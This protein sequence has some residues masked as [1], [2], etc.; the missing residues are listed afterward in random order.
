MNYSSAA[1]LALLVHIIIHFNVIRNTHYRKEQP[2]AK[3]YRWMILSVGAFYVFDALWGV[4]YSARL[5]QAVAFDTMLYFLSMG[6]TMFFW[7]RF[8]VLYL[9]EKN[10]FAKAISIIGCLLI[11]MIAVLLIINLFTPV[12]FWFDE[13]GVYHAGN[14][15]YAILL[16]QIL[17]FILASVYLMATLPKTESK[18]RKHHIAI[19]ISGITVAAM[20]ILQAIF[21]LQPF[22]SI[23]CLLGTCIIHTF[24]VGDMEYDRRIELEE[25]L[26]REAQ[27][28]K[29]LGSAKQLAYTDSLTGVKSSHA[30][31]EI[32][33][34]VDQRI[35][36][37]DIRE[38]GVVVFDLNGLKEINDTKGHDAGNQYIQGGCRIICE[39]FKHS[40]VFRI[41]GDEFVAFLEGEDFRN[42]KIILAAFETQIDENVRSGGPVVASGMA[43]FRHGKDNSY[44][45]VFERADQR[46]YDRK[47]VLKAMD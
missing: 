23:G 41:G 32:E 46:M 4:L 17:L 2:S 9:G 30:Y 22:Y 37:D 7:T 40:P 16:I 34:Q 15:R 25:M 19:A 8:V 11:S 18:D 26:R 36:D 39:H 45:R 5:T 27:Q 6:A 42:R 24:V 35:T 31:V 43:V 20:D 21:P 14:L 44:R 33:K 13:S 28:E 29:E 1:L 38:F 10:R 3:A 12:M 47:G